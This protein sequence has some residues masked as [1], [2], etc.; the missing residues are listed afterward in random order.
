MVVTAVH[1]ERVA[2]PGARF[3]DDGD[4]GVDGDVPRQAGALCDRRRGHQ[5]A[6]WHYRPVVQRT[7]STTPRTTDSVAAIRATAAS[8]E[9]T[10]RSTRATIA[11]TRS[12]IAN[13]RCPSTLI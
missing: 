6:A 2:M 4:G 8:P 10:I 11:S 13:S 1:H 12:T 9:S 7:L 5:Q 3:G